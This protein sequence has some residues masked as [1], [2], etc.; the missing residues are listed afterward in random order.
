MSYAAIPAVLAA[1][2]YLLALI[3]AAGR[4]RAK[5]RLCRHCPP[6]S[7]LKPVHGR[8]PGFYDAIRSHATQD[9]PEFE[10]LFGVRDPD[11]PAIDDIERLIAEFPERAI[12][13][14]Y[15]KRRCMNG[16][17]G[18][19]A[20]M[21]GQARFPVLLVNDS[22]IVVEADYL[23]NV[24]APLEDPNVGLA[25]CLYRARGESRAT[26][27]EA[28]GIATEFAPGVLVARLI[29]MAGFALGSTM[30]FRAEQLRAI[31]GFNA[32]ADYLADDYQL[33]HKISELGYR[34]ALAEAVVETNLGGES[35]AQVWRHQLRW[36]RTI[37]VSNAAG[38][39]GYA[40]TQA[41]FWSLLALAAG[42][43]QVA[44]ASLAIR[45]AAG[46]LCG[47]CV[48]GDRSILRQW[49]LIPLRDLW[50]FASWFAGLSG[51]TVEW[52]GRHLELT[53]DGRIMP[54]ETILPAPGEKTV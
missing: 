31:G 8:D 22:D 26:R 7:I 24:V 21:A 28:M 16:K 40:V 42:A 5:R 23:R 44:L 51:N 20:E 48:L 34:V 47:A 33:G 41:S 1:V 46:V 13:L 52:R 30:V 35:W 38:Y 2:Y 12:R 6:V 53:S 54:P 49:P 25:T 29:G 17:V 50:G 3:A 32:I 37:R 15:V 4:M 9:Y 14:V 10:I 45:I 19:L 39:Y 11:D 36:Q 27:W 43:W 18:A